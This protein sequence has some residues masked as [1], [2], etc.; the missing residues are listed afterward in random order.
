MIERGLKV[1]FQ[2]FDEKGK[3]K[4]PFERTGLF[5]QFDDE[6]DY[7][8]RI[9]ADDTEKIIVVPRHRVKFNGTFYGESEACGYCAVRNKSIENGACGR[10][11]RMLFVRCG[12][13][14]EKDT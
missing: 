7:Q 3:P 2:F 12:T 6:N 14:N 9:L 1:E 13:L 8:V 10:G 11:N 4:E 5:L